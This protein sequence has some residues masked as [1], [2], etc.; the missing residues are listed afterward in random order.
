MG[1][2][3]PSPQIQLTCWMTHQET[4]RDGSSEHYMQILSGE[5]GM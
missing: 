5:E 1:T 4:N 2:Q 3:E